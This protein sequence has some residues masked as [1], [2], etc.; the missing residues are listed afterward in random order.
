MPS[1]AL[2]PDSARLSLFRDER[3]VLALFS[4]AMIAGEPLPHLTNFHDKLTNIQQTPSAIA[5]AARSPR[6]RCVQAP[7]HRVVR[8]AQVDPSQ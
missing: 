3:V 1:P 5:G 2:A 7:A 8:H 6:V 4:Q